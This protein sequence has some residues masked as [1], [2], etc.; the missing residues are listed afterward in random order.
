[1]DEKDL[2]MYKTILKQE[3]L[4]AFNE[5]P[6]DFKSITTYQEDPE[7]KKHFLLILRSMQH[8]VQ[9]VQSLEKADAL[10][11]DLFHEVEDSDVLFN[12]EMM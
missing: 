7:I 3:F 6:V 5:H 9:R 1:M 4:A 12:Q 11:K 10:L 2:D 8:I